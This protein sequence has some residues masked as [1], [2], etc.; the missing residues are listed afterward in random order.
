VGEKPGKVT[1]FDQVAWIA[2]GQEGA[3]GFDRTSAGTIP[4]DA[5]LERD[6]AEGDSTFRISDHY[7]LWVEFALPAR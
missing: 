7:P 6:P 3:L 1:A 5:L 2:K 4:W